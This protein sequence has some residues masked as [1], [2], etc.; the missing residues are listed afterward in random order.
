MAITV[1]DVAQ[2]AGVATSTVSRVVNNHPS[3][4]EATRR[5]VQK[6]MQE[7]GYVPNIAA[8][9]LGKQTSNAIGI[10]L[11]PLNSKE[12][13]ANPFFLEIIEAINDEARRNNMT[14]AVA[15]AKNLEDLL[16]DVKVMHKQKQV[17]GFILAYAHQGDPVIKYLL[18]KQI[19]FTLIGQPYTQHNIISY[20]DNDNQLLGQ[21]ATEHLI[22]NGHRNIL[23]VTNTIKEGI[24][25]ER[26]F[27]YQKAMMLNQLKVFDSI[28]IIEHTDYADFE[29]TLIRTKA[30]AIV[31]LDD[32]FALRVMQLVQ[33][34]GYKVPDNLS[35]ISFNNSILSTLTHPYLTTIDI[36]TAKLGHES[37]KMLIKHLNGEDISN[38]KIVVPHEL[39]ERETV[40][41]LK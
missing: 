12:R 38:T 34:Y 9:N 17:G 29:D 19:A 22:E 33:M 37:V 32:I 30:T 21:H 40:I 26:Y 3:I 5:K 41:N 20:I 25:F 8:R 23:F 39:I 24:Y 1:K 4:S 6:V 15:I 16:E 36:D 35:V 13:M 27:G 18:E 7:M 2:Q 14:T 31:V 11:P 10:I 28:P